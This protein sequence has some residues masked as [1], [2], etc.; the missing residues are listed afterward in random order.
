MIAILAFGATL[1][2]ADMG[3][4]CDLRME[5]SQIFGGSCNALVGYY[6]GFRVGPFHVSMPDGSAATAGTCE[7]YVGVTKVEGN[8]ISLSAF[9]SVPARIYTL[10]DDC[11][12][13]TKWQWQ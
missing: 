11:R 10:A 3:V 9:H 2:V 5:P 7:G 12:S 13:T 8:T 4:A 1:T 6:G